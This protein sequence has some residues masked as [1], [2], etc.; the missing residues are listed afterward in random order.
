VA[1]EPPLAEET[2]VSLEGETEASPEH[3]AVP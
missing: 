3:V 1:D 2:V